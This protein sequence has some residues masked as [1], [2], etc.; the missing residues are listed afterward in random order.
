MRRTLAC[1]YGSR[2]EF[3]IIVDR[4]VDPIETSSPLGASRLLW[5]AT[6]L[7]DGVNSDR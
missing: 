6:Q 1:Q 7:A 5:Q 2:E 3:A 4:Q